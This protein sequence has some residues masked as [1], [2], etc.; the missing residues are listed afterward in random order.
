LIVVM[1]HVLVL[2]FPCPYNPA[3]IYITF[4]HYLTAYPHLT[5]QCLERIEIIV[6]PKP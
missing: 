4:S 5:D 6:D 2:M 3:I 1:A